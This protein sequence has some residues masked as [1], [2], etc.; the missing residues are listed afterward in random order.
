MLNITVIGTID[1]TKVQ[2][3]FG[4]FHDSNFPIF[5]ANKVFIKIG[6]MSTHMNVRFC[7]ISLRKQPISSCTCFS[8]DAQSTLLTCKLNHLR[9]TTPKNLVLDS[10][11]RRLVPRT[12]TM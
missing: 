3:K 7:T 8:M 12:N 5:C 1:E 2:I 10:G 4:T 11:H 9:L 6:E